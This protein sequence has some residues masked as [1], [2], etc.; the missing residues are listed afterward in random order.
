MP[1][2]IEIEQ[3]DDGRW[4]AAVPQL[5]GTQQYG[6]TRDEAIRLV[7]AWRIRPANDHPMSVPLDSNW[8]RSRPEAVR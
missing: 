7:Q 5:P 6:K 3:E 2:M 8:G 1:L 4:I